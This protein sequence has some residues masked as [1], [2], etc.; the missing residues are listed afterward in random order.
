MLTRVS[1][2]PLI[3]VLSSTLL[4]SCASYVVRANCEKMNWFAYGKSVALQGKRI[5][6]DETI[7]KCAEVEAQIDEV[8][9]DRGF[10]A[11]VE[12]Y[13]QPDTAYQVGRSGEYFS[14]EMCD[15]E[16][17]RFLGAKH[18]EG[19]RLFCQPANA[20]AYGAT[21]KGYNRICPRALEASFLPQ[22]NRGRRSFIN[23]TIANNEDEIDQINAE[24]Y[25]LQS[26]K[27]R[28]YGQISTLGPLKTVS[29]ETVVDPYTGLTRLVPVEI[30][31]HAA[32]S[33]K[34]SY[35]RELRRNDSEITDALEKQKR[36]RERNRDLRVEMTAAEAT[37]DN[38]S[39]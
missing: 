21:G 17:P 22:Y 15:G 2:L 30:D 19:V 31:N 27:M 34:E 23:A 8:G 33:Q 18:A 38:A 7:R 11:G 26:E 29:Y 32:L 3:A 36:L 37:N 10:K 12:R 9:I 24:I 4:T 35:E 6:G 16:R 1:L 13:C 28:A 14:I 39:L 20:F 5:S 25:R